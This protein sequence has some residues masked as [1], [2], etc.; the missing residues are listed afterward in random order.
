MDCLNEH[1]ENI[2]DVGFE[3]SHHIISLWIID[4]DVMI[5]VGCL[6]SVL[7]KSN[8][9]YEAIASDDYSYTVWN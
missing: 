9:I 8:T 7:V 2:R 6:F 5:L 1:E 4:D 3:T